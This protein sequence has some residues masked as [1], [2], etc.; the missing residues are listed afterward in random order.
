MFKYLD[1]DGNNYKINTSKEFFLDKIITIKQ[2][3]LEKIFDFAYD[4]TE[5]ENIEVIEVE[6]Q[7]KEQTDKNL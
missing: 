6:E 1:N 5:K 3:G 7:K 4:M 2:K